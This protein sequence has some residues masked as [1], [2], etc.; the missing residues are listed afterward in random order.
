VDLIATDPLAAQ[1]ALIKAGFTEVA[2]THDFSADDHLRP[3]TWP[4]V[5]LLVEVHRQ[6]SSPT[7]L[8]SPSAEE[9]LA[10]AVPSATGI[11]G[12]L[13]PAPAAHALLLV[14]HS[15]THL[16]LGRL[17]D[18]LDVAAVLPGDARVEADA[19]AQRWGWERMWRMTLATADSLFDGGAPTVPLRTWAR[20]LVAVREPSVL[21]SHLSNLVAPV[22]ALEPAH[23]LRGFGW[24][25]GQLLAPGP[26]E[27]WL[28]K[29]RRMTRALRNPLQS[30][31]QHDR[32]V[33]R[34]PWSR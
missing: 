28:E 33:G 13:A 2:S 18:L 26:D 12:L 15:W 16:P 17:S 8:A 24:A 34:N 31:S 19:L 4:G 7:Y 25:V 14:G 21:E 22:V 20:Q 11:D 5:P 29:L 9:V 23:A 27:Q 10:L 6:P 1:R 3:L 32:D 30:K